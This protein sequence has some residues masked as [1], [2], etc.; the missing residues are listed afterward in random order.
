MACSRFLSCCVVEAMVSYP[1]RRR[2]TPPLVRWQR[3]VQ[4]RL[5]VSTD[6][7]RLTT[8]DLA[9]SDPHFA[10][11]SDFVPR[12]RKGPLS[13]DGPV[14]CISRMSASLPRCLPHLL[15]GASTARSLGS[16]A[17]PA[18]FGGVRS[19]PGS[20][21]LWPHL[22]RRPRAAVLSDDAGWRPAS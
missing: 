22:P 4:C 20:R 16:L 11:D 13:D 18:C 2:S 12:P 3:D 14:L 1:F 21:Y 7:S 19:F 5:V 17:D 10:C 9:R 6:A 15:P 8:S